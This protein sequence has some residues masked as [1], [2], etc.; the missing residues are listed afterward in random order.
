MTNI[1]PDR[2]ISSFIFNHR[3]I[4][5]I[6]VVGVMAGAD[7]WSKAWAQSTLATER[8]ISRQ[9]EVAGEMTT[10]DEKIYVP[11]REIVVISNAFSLIYKENPAAAFSLGH[12]WPDWLRK[13]LLLWVSVIASI[14]FLIW[15]FRLK[16]ED[17]LLLTAF[18]LIL[19][20]ALGNLIDRYMAGFVVDFL[21]VYAGFLGYP[22]A[23]WPTFNIA[24]SCIV[25]GA[26]FVFFKAFKSEKT[27]ASVF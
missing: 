26:I 20:G 16:E 1:T 7:Q 3:L 19:A 5:L 14:F 17:G 9:I 8:T 4:W 18:C 12:N 21:D 15:Y 11:T 2:P 27:T 10:V 25:V 6:L 22:N 23:H 13:P 24:D